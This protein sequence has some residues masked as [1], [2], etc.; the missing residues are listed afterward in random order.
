MVNI[1]IES[2]DNDFHAACVKWALEQQGHT[3]TIWDFA[4]FPEKQSLSVRMTKDGGIDHIMHQDGHQVCIEDFDVVWQRRLCP[5]KVNTNI[6]EADREF[7]YYQSKEH[8]LGFIRSSQE[9]NQFHVNPLTAAHA[10]NRKIPQLGLARAC[11]FTVPETLFSNN[12]ADIAAFIE[13]QPN[14]AIFK[15]FRPNVWKNGDDAAVNYT[16]TLT[17]DMLEDISA[18]KLSPGIFQNAIPKQ[19]E[20]RAVFMGHTNISLKFDSQQIEENTIDWRVNPRALPMSRIE[21]PEQ[22]ETLCLRFMKAAGLVFGSF[23]FIV[24]TN[25]N[26]VFLEINEQG[27]FLGY[28]QPDAPLLQP[29][30]DFLTSGDP[31]FD[32]KPPARCLRVADYTATDE[33]TAYEKTIGND[34]S[35]RHALYVSQE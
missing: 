10:I 22:V 18:I 15:S 7:A 27:Q 11:G 1:L 8:M 12:V 14:G 4:H 30:M 3:A 32:W 24:D 5:V 2:L 23:D 35:H 34:E 28:E 21:L 9:N 25:G 19:F 6:H 29:F 33:Y 13:A 17:A 16:I 31:Q 20:V 26:Y